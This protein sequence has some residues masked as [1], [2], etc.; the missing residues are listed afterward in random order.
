MKTTRQGGFFIRSDSNGS[1]RANRRT[2]LCLVILGRMPL[3]FFIDYS[4]L[5]NIC[6]LAG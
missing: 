6:V 5:P 2:R 4:N 1:I 3:I